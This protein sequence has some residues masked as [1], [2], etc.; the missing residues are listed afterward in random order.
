MKQIDINSFHVAPFFPYL[1]L[2][3]WPLPFRAHFNT[4]LWYSNW[5]SNLV[6]FNNEQNAGY[7]LK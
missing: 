2:R 3:P 1:M 4:W 5:N 6:H 7:S